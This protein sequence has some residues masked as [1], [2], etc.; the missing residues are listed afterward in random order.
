MSRSTEIIFNAQ[1]QANM[2]NA[3][4]LIGGNTLGEP[5]FA[6]VV[7]MVASIGAMLILFGW[8]LK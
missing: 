4:Q 8:L 7:F 3:A 6:A 5:S 2:Q 1:T